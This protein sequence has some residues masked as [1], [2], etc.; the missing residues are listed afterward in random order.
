MG[1]PGPGMGMPGPGMMG[2][3]PKRGGSGALIG[4][5]VGGVLA[6]VLII[7]AVVVVVAINSGPSTKERLTLA[8]NELNTARA[9]T[10][11][12]S[13]SAGSDN[14]RGEMLVTKGGRATGQVD[15]TGDNVTVLSAEDKVFVKAPKDY[16]EDK[17]TST[18][19]ER[20]LKEGEQWGQVRESE[21][22]V[23]FHEDLTPAALATEMRR[24]ALRTGLTSTETT[25]GGE[26]AHKISTSLTTFYVSDGEEPELLRYEKGSSPRVSADVTVQSTRDGSGP[27]GQMRTTMGELTD[28]FDAGTTASNAAKPEFVS[29]DK[30]G[31]PCTVKV[32]VSSTRT[33]D[34]SVQV[35]VNFKLTS[36]QGGGR[37]YGNCE[38]TGTVTGLTPVTV[39]CTISGGDWAKHG[40]KARRVWVSAAPM[41]IAATSADVRALQQGL[42]AE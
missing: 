38:A 42:D 3:P 35:K 15:W 41:A 1:M 32:R 27:I 31:A 11:K 14:L 13:F 18:V 26:K 24:L 30:G 2:P 4:I 40:K 12:G 39:Q 17:L 9:V 8:S 29:C 28:S 19:A 22:S 6:V 21:L 33:G 25:V 37:H 36:E 16:W 10:Y 20:F 23:K 34:S 7:V 5:I